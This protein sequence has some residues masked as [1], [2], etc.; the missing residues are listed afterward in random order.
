MQFDKHSQSEPS[1]S[2]SDA[3][4]GRPRAKKKARPRSAASAMEP[5]QLAGL[6]RT[7]EGEIVPRLLIAL[8]SRCLPGNVAAAPP[9]AASADDV[10]ELVRL[11]IARGPVDAAAFVESVRLRGTPLNRIC[12][13]L[14]APAARQL[15]TM[16]E[17]EHCSFSDLSYALSGLHALLQE[18]SAAGR[19]EHE[20]AA[21]E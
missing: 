10:S 18:V 8:R 15:G 6:V 4:D 13:D 12:L 2:W 5:E 9:R 11:L 7:I 16:W 3:I 20:Q 19:G 14:L 21:R 1:E 17:R